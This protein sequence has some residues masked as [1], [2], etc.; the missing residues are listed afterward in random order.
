MINMIDKWAK[1]WIFY[2]IILWVSV[3]IT[4][5]WDII[6]YAPYDIIGYVSSVVIRVGLMMSLTYGNLYF[7]IPKIFPKSKGLYWSLLLLSIFLFVIVY[8]PLYFITTDKI[9]EINQPQPVDAYF[10]RTFIA[11]RYLLISV[12]LKFLQ[13]W[14]QQERKIS[15]IKVDQLSIE[16]KLLRAQVNPHF[17][18]NTLNNLYGLA[19]KKSDKTPEIILRLS[20][21][22]DFMLYEVNEVKVFL[23]KDVDNLINYVEIEKIRQGN[24]ARIN[25]TTTGDIKMQKIIPLLMLTLLENGFKHGVNRMPAHACLEAHLTVY[26]ASIEFI[27][28]NNK[29]PNPVTSDT[30]HGIGLQN[31]RKRLT[32]FYPKKHVLTI[33]EGIDSFKAFL[34]IELT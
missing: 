2:H 11:I 18:F 16:L 12:F 19:L 9:Y 23:K 15:Q 30:N 25:F 10:S 28:T 8:K 21:M 24:N 31:L 3:A 1:N 34:K 29:E 17:L 7:L 26:P 32:L 20:D 14:F 4:L 6:E 33:D 13:G 5:F 22:M 27:V